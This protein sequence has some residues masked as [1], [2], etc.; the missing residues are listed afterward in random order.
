[1]TQIDWEIYFN[2]LQI[3]WYRFFIALLDFDNIKN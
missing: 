3:T 2:M 1:M